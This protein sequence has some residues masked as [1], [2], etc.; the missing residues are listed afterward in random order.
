M[1]AAEK[2]CGGCGG[3]FSGGEIFCP[4]DGLRLRGAGEPLRPRGDPLLGTLLG[5]RYRVLRPIGE[6][7]MGIVYEAEHVVIEKRVALKVLRDDYSERSDV[8]ERFRQEARS[9]SRIGH[10]NIVDVSDFGET[11]S[12]A[13]YFV[14]EMLRGEDL[15]DILARD[16]ALS[17]MRA[18]GIIHQCSKALAA[19]HAKGIV[20]RDLKPENIFL[21]ERDGQP[22]F[23]KIVDFGVAK[24]SDLESLTPGRRLTKTGMIFG[25]PEYMSPEQAQGKPLDHR[26]DIYALGVMLYELITGKVPFE[27]DNFMEILSKHANDPLPPLAAMNPGVRISPEL[28]AVVVRALEKERDTRLQTMSE[29][30]Q[31]LEATPEMPANLWR[32]SSVPPD[33]SL[34][35]PPSLPVRPSA[36][37]VVRG[38]GPEQ[39][40]HRWHLGVGLGAVALLLGVVGLW[41]AGAEDDPISVRELPAAVVAAEGSSVLHASA[42][43]GSTSDPAA[44]PI[45]ASAGLV[46]VRVTTKP[47]GASLR[48]AGRGEVCGSTP[49][50]FEARR[51]EPLTLAARRGRMAASA[52]LVAAESTELH[53]ILT[54]NEATTTPRSNKLPGDLKVPAAFR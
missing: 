50:E 41:R 42:A 25:T 37:T 27:G 26:V 46:K 44:A 53:L 13:S 19:A 51:G 33:W 6:G 35:P 39:A 43:H 54:G 17:P 10:R 15:A 29:L 5:E 31:A 2:T 23:V 49:C 11:P 18:V 12:G 47:S 36:P 3:R 45:A 22:D 4:T 40:R 16:T 1:Q 52:E 7:G 48:L 34:V 20:H 9:A 24:M 38:P 32:E 21:T 14:M 30:A 8:V 28:E